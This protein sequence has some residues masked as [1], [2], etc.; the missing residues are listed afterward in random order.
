[1]EGHTGDTHHQKP[2]PSP[3]TPPPRLPAARG[4]G[5]ENI[6]KG[7]NPTILFHE[8][9]LGRRQEDNLFKQKKKKKETHTRAL[10]VK[11]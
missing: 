2:T 8:P 3:S 1:M 6:G 5:A 10:R 9:R 4:E 7:T 11:V